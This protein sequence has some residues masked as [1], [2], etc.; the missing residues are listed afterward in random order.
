MNRIALFKDHFIINEKKKYKLENL[1]NFCTYVIT[2]IDKSVTIKSLMVDGVLPKIDFWTVITNEGYLQ[3]VLSYMKANKAKQH[4]CEIIVNFYGE[5]NTYD[6]HK[7]KIINS[8]KTMTFKSIA[9]KGGI[10]NLKIWTE[11]STYSD[12]SGRVEGKNER[13]AIDLCDPKDY[14]NARLVLD[15]NFN[16]YKND[17]KMEKTER[18]GIPPLSVLGTYKPTVFELI[19]ALAFEFTFHGTPE[20]SKARMKELDDRCDEIKSKDFVGKEIKFK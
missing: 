1:F 7:T 20:N 5:S 15:N 10:R 17:Y 12:V 16:V 3:S 4:I 9:P 13:Y 18:N 14:K 2:K 19:K 11:F 6:N 8:K